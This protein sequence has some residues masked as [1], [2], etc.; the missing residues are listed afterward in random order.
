MKS[1]CRQL[2]IIGILINNR[3]TC[4]GLQANFS[5]PIIGQPLVANQCIEWWLVKQCQP[6]V[7][8][9]AS[10]PCRRCWPSPTS[11]RGSCSFDPLFSSWGPGLVC[12]TRCYFAECLI[13]HSF[14]I[15]CSCY[16]GLLSRSSVIHVFS[17]FRCSSVSV[18][19]N[20]QDHINA[21]QGHEISYIHTAIP[22]VW[23]QYGHHLCSKLST[24]QWL[25]CSTLNLSFFFRGFGESFQ[26]IWVKL[27]I[28][29][30]FYLFQ[31]FI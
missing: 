27:Q 29:L 2:V 15:Y 18:T 11:I 17:F 12:H 9:Q 4:L 31:K 16:S 13:F 14:H 5:L 1:Q 28:M 20:T 19:P 30:S 21:S 23:Y 10:P 7:T 6:M 26:W 25:S 8:I 22:V 3:C 24:E